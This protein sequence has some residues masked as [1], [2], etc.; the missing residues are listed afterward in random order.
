[1]KKIVCTLMAILMLAGLV[2]G[3]GVA[4][5]Q[6]TAT[7]TAGASTTSAAGQTTGSANT[8]PIK[9]AVV[10]PMTGSLAEYGLTA[11]L[12]AQLAADTINA[13]G[14]LLGGR[15]VEIVIYDDKG[16]PEDAAALAEKIV[17]D[18]SITAVASGHCQSSVALVAC[19]RYQEAGIVSISASSSHP[20]Y[21]KI[22]DFVFRNNLTDLPEAQNTIQMAYNRGYRKIGVVSMKSDFGVSSANSLMEIAKVVNEKTPMEVSLISYFV[23]GTV[24]FSPNITEL[25]NAG[26][27]C[28]IMTSEYSSFAP[29]AMQLRKSGSTTPLIGVGVCYTPELINLGGSAVE[30]VQFPCIFNPDTT[31]PVAVPFVKAYTEANK[32]A[33]DY[34]AAQV[35]DSCFAIFNAIKMTNSDDRT[36]IKDALYKVDFQG[37]SG[38]MKFDEHGETHKTEIVL[39]IKGGKFSEVPNAIK[40]WDEFLSSIK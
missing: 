3:C 1:M 5:G 9:L 29:F 39:E 10:G 19:P 25:K 21:A 12:G 31:D 26:L 40:G 36:A 4:S 37:V 35:Y 32:R 13:E 8:N 6:T 11:R 16:S 34:I 20:D 14:G 7:T 38:R 33:P 30:G 15:Q 28:I 17:A 18:D 24:D 27:D 23:D 22:G 2:A